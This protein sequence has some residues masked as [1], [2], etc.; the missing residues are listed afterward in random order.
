MRILPRTADAIQKHEALG[1]LALGIA[2][3]A[4][5]ASPALAEGRQEQQHGRPE[6]SHGHPEYGDR[7]WNNHEGQMR[8]QWKHRRG[9]Q[10][11]HYVYTPPL[12]Y[13]PP[14]EYREPGF[15]LIL[16]L[17]FH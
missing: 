2:L 9:Y 7:D 6:Q 5:I 3:I 11:P 16:P 14:P 13:A 12:V 1:V 15:N 17:H 4:L 8:R 10:E